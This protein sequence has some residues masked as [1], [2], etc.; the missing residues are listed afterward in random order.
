VDGFKDG[1][2][3]LSPEVAVSES[4]TGTESTKGPWDS[5]GGSIETSS[6]ANAVGGGV[7]TVAE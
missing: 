5:T 2:C 6:W 3:A 4:G 7:W 1:E